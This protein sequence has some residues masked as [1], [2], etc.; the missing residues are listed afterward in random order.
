[1]FRW[2]PRRRAQSAPPA[3]TDLV[4]RPLG[5]LIDSLTGTGGRPEPSPRRGATDAVVD[6]A[7]YADGV[8][9]PGALHYAEAA[10]HVRRHRDAFVWL[11]LHEPDAATMRAVAREFRLHELTAEQSAVGGHRPVAE[12]IGDVTRLVLRTAR[13]IE[14][15]T[16]TETSEVVDT[17]DVTVLI[18][19]RFVITVRHGAPGAL[20]H[21][22]QGLEQRKTLLDAGPWSVA[23]AVCSAMVEGYLDVAGHVERDLERL[24]EAAFVPDRSPGIAQMYQLKR[25]M[26]EFK[27]AVLPLQEPLHRMLDQADLPVVLRPY[28]VDVRGRLARAVDRVAGFDDLLNSILQAR[29]AQ[30]A[31][32]QNNDMRKIA[33]WAAIA[34]VQTAIAGVYGMNF[35]HMPELT[36]TY[37]YPGVL[38]LMAVAAV[39]LHRR[40]KRAGWL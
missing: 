24:E 7:V 30:V 10:R 39:L 17:G 6:C 29:L 38:A 14:H 35:E 9:R 26:V 1:M 27:R 20:W 16:L 5:R 13:Y 3:L 8:R 31:I 40:L 33:S 34:A 18:G 28:F 23:Y 21:V 12:S 4:T 2:L 15:E 22:R 11:G 32:D 36:W 19:D 25:E 37:G